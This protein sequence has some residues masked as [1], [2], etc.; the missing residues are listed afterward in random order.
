MTSFDRG[1]KG[2]IINKASLLLLI[3]AVL[4]TQLAATVRLYSLL[5]AH[6]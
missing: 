6:T 3:K 5:V 2:L 4:H 1:H